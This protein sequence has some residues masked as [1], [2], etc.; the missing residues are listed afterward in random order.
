MTI[1]SDTRRIYP[2]KDLVALRDYLNLLIA[3][4]APRFLE[5]AKVE[6]TPTFCELTYNRLETRKDRADKKKRL[7]THSEICAYIDSE[8]LPP[9]YTCGHCTSSAYVLSTS[10]ALRGILKGDTGWDWWAFCRSPNCQTGI[11]G[12]LYGTY[13]SGW[14]KRT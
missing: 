10:K 9:D 5:T 8:C 4:V 12:M 2:P 14:L 7:A 6:I 1:I 13:D 3:E 11:G